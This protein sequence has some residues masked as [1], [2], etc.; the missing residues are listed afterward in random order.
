MKSLDD[1]ECLPNFLG[2]NG[3]VAGRVGPNRVCVR[4]FVVS[5]LICLGEVETRYPCM[6]PIH[7]FARTAFLFNRT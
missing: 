4:K 5:Q 1:C 7:C 6:Q 3:V 2:D